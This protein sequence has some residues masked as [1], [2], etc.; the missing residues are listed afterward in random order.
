[1]QVTQQNEFITHAV[2]GGKQSI[3]FGISNSAEFFNILSSTLYKDQILAVVREV[4]CNAWD[5]HIEAGCTDRPVQVTLDSDKFTIKDFGKGIHHDDMGLI[6]GTY[7]NSTKKNDG[8]QTGGFG[9]G[10]KAPFAYTDHFEVTSCHAGTKTIYNL[11]KSSAQAQGK[12]GIIP[13]ASFPSDESGLTVSIRIK[14]TDRNRFSDL[15][16][17]IVHNGDMNMTLNGEQLDVLGF[18]TSKGNYLVLLSG[19]TLDNE[20]RIMVR[21]GNVIYPIDNAKEIQQQYARI[22]T[23]LNSLNKSYHNYQIIFQ[24]PPHSISVTPSRESLSMQEHTVNTLNKLFGD[25]LALMDRDFLKACD[26]CAKKSVQEAV[27]QKNIGALLVRNDCLPNHE[28]QKRPTHITDLAAMA[29]VYMQS[30]YP[31]SLKYR[32]E[33]LSNRLQLMAQNNL[34]ER[35]KVQTFLVAMKAVQKTYSPYY[36]YSHNIE[37][38]SWLQKRIIAPLLKKILL[39]GLDINKLFLLDDHDSNADKKNNNRQPLVPAV[40]AFPRHLFA[41]LP[42][43]RNIVV[44]TSRREYLESS[45]YQHEIFKDMGTYNGFFVYIPGRKVSETEAARKFFANSGM[46]VVDLTIQ[47]GVEKNTAKKTHTPRKPAQKGLARLDSILSKQYLGSIYTDC[48]K[49]SDAVRIENPEF[50][51][52]VSFKQGS[53]D[54]LEGWSPSISKL[55]VELF[56][57]KGGVTTTSAIH[58]KWLKKGAKELDSYVEEKV[59]QYMLTNPR[60]QEYWAFNPD[61]L[62]DS[63]DYENTEKLFETIYRTP[64]L[65]QEFKLINNLTD[66]DMKYLAIWGYVKGSYRKLNSPEYLKASTHLDAIPLDPANNALLAKF[67]NNPFTSMIDVYEFLSLIRKN[68]PVQVKKAFEILISAL[69]N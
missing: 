52:K 19:N 41:T 27:A 49:D 46:R 5:A 25:F 63:L 20:T 23:Y 2:I 31:E 32:K 7:G 30:N 17:R 64:L 12:P 28:A 18:D 38:S 6:Y 48:A 60:I 3:E 39:A 54:R 29:Q 45:A 35:G 14:P 10:C 58:E 11:S 22:V 50:I 33:D 53:K 57:D 51:S 1:M 8:K 62:Q 56:G 34:L 59:S 13:I 61:R 9:L 69:N 43:L 67:K 66:V 55:I 16:K 40:K 44:I 15:I 24:A 26:V 68:N 65:R 36:I 21:Y 47:Q 4:L 37:R 42:Y